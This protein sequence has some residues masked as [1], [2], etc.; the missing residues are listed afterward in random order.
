LYYIGGVAGTG[1]VR[2]SISAGTWTALTTTGGTA[3]A[4]NPGAGLSGNWIYGCT[5]T[6]SGTAWNNK[7]A[8]KNGRYIYSFRGGATAVLDILDIAGGDTTGTT[9]SWPATVLAYGNQAETFSTGQ[10]WQYDGKD[11]I[12]GIGGVA[13]LPARGYKFN[14]PTFTLSPIHSINYPQGTMVVGDKAILV[15]YIDGATRIDF[16]YHWKNSGTEVFRSIVSPFTY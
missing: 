8:I 11:Y 12:Y 6:V 13:A 5:D 3:R 16:L 2:F 10:V 14:I 7:N 4:A 9:I 1:V 15:P